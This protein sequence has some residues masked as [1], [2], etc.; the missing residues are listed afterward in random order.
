MRLYTKFILTIPLF[1]GFVLG[2]HGGRLALLEIETGRPVEVFP[3]HA[4]RL[5]PADQKRRAEGIPVD[6]PQA[7]A[8]LLE[9]YL[10]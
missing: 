7:L 5:P 4:S 2:M 9:D 6:S 8:R 1:C 10:S 3:L